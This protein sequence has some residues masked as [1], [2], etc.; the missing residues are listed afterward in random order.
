MRFLLARKV[1]LL[2]KSK[3]TVCDNISSK[4]AYRMKDMKDV[5]NIKRALA[6]KYAA[7]PRKLSKQ[8]IYVKNSTI[9]LLKGNINI[10]YFE[11]DVNSKENQQALIQQVVNILEESIA[12][13]LFGGILQWPSSQVNAKTPFEYLLGSYKRYQSIYSQKM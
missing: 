2:C 3:S 4:S 7:Q 9:L 13:N 11:Q 1:R 12:D 5:I 10:S 6:L 8:C